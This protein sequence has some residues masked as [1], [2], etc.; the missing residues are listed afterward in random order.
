MFR[1]D[2]ITKDEFAKEVKALLSLQGGRVILGVEDDG[3]VTGIT[4]DFLKE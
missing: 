4:R 2:T 3:S 1:P